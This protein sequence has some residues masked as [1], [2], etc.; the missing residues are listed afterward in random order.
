MIAEF[1]A[2]RRG[3]PVG[4]L[5]PQVVAWT[6]LATSLAAYEEWLRSEDGDVVEIL[7]RA[8]TIHDI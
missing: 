7:N 3:L 8:I 1:V 4:S 6:L 2:R 5:E